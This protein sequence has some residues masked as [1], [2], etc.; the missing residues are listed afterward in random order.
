MLERIVALLSLSDSSPRSDGPGAVCV[1]RAACSSRHGDWSKPRFIVGYMLTLNLPGRERF[2][3]LTA[4]VSHTENRATYC[5]SS[6]A[7]GSLFSVA[8][9]F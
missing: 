2:M 7:V 6:A 9:F 3:K 5:V 8:I 1:L 4:T